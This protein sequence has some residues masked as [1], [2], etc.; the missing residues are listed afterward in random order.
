MT[1][2]FL[3]IADTHLGYRQYHRTERMYDFSNAFLSAL[4][5]GVAEGVDF[6][7]IAGDIFNDADVSPEG[8]TDICNRIYQFKGESRAKLKREIPIIAIEGNH[9]FRGYNI[10]NSWLH[11]LAGL[12]LITLLAD[13][14]DPVKKTISFPSVASGEHLG[15][16]IKVKD[17]NIYGMSYK[18]GNTARKI[19]QILAAIPAA[20]GCLNILMMHCGLEGQVKRKQGEIQLDALSELHEKVD[21]LALGHFH[22]QY[23]LPE[24]D[25]WIFN[26]GSLEL[27]DSTVFFDQFDR[28]AFIVTLNPDGPQKIVYQTVKAVPGGE[29]SPNTISNRPV[30]PLREPLLIGGEE[31]INF[32]DTVNN[33]LE[34]LQRYGIPPKTQEPANLQR[35]VQLPML[36]L[37]L[38]GVLEYSRLEFNIPALR[39]AILNKF[40]LFE[41][42]IYPL[43][44]SKLDE[45]PSDFA[46]KISPEEIEAHAFK[47]IVEK[48]P[49][50]KDRGKEIVSL[51]QSLK[52]IVLKA[53]TGSI[54]Q[55]AKDTVKQ[56]YFQAYGNPEITEPIKATPSVIN[57]QQD[58]LSLKNST[59]EA[60]QPS[61]PKS[62]KRHSVDDFE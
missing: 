34:K 9:D 52:T 40:Q 25:P 46:G 59:T 53:K 26:P 17:A 11:F 57:V 8:L 12:G 38:N 56:W 62:K 37:T 33:I 20:E 7:L 32:E 43:F 42:R 6:V 44:S 58:V 39:K 61:K 50:Y 48:S 19:P 45:T 24:K 41:C 31:E 13:K 5:I 36:F 3:H 60:P 14:Y 27:V 21:Y 54:A 35:G 15:G 49:E 4:Q 23:I 16:M 10:E 22:K 47:I 18:G 30:I 2:R 51:I 29:T 1:V 55:S 28:G